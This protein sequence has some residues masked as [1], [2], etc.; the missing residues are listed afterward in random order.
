MDFL[1]ITTLTIQYLITD[2]IY[3]LPPPTHTLQGIPCEVG[4]PMK[5]GDTIRLEHVR[6]HSES[7]H[8]YDIAIEL[9]HFLRK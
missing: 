7:D 5:C 1:L 3:I 8:P 4:K 6:T 9:F 2:H